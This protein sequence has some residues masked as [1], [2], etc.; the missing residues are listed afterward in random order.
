MNRYHVSLGDEKVNG[1]MRVR[2][3]ADLASQEVAQLVTAAN[4]R[5]AKGAAAA[6]KV[7]REQ[8]I[9]A[10]PVLLIDGFNKR[11]DDCLVVLGGHGVRVERPNID[12]Y[13][14]LTHGNPQ[15]CP[16][17]I[18]NPALVEHGVWRIG[19]LYFAGASSLIHC[20][21]RPALRM[22]VG[23][24]RQ[25]ANVLVKSQPNFFAAA[26]AMASMVIHF[27]GRWFVTRLVVARK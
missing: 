24:H 8:L 9:E 13:S 5:L 14:S 15:P 19:R 2:K 22:C 26:L 18:K 20:G 1:L 16:E 7:G 4:L 17:G 25:V 12:R 6:N 3:R 23:R 21:L 11:S 27:E 10:P